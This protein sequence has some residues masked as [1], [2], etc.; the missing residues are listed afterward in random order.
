MFIAGVVG[1]WNLQTWNLKAPTFLCE[2]PRTIWLVAPHSIHTRVHRQSVDALAECEES[3]MVKRPREGEEE[4][5]RGA[6][7]PPAEPAPETPVPG[8]IPQAAP[9]VGGI[10]PAEPPPPVD[11]LVQRERADRAERAE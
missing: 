5:R 1:D 3:D 8:A 6:T 10:P 4:K 9:E 7:P 2:I 11:E